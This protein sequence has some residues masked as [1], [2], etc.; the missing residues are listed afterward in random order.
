V[1]DP[2]DV[3]AMVMHGLIANLQDDAVKQADERHKE[4]REAMLALRQESGARGVSASELLRELTDD[5]PE[6]KL[7]ELN[8]EM[9][10]VAAE[11]EA[12]AKAKGDTDEDLPTDRYPPPVITTGTP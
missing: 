2:A 11:A 5:D 4:E 10:R 3:V 8:N 6:R 9:D 1:S 7:K 12:A